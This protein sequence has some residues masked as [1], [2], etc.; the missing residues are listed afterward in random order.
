MDARSLSVCGQ[1]QKNV[2]FKF[3]LDGNEA[4]EI[5]CSEFLIQKLEYTHNNSVRAEIIENP[6]DYKYRSAINNADRK[7]LLEVI[8]ISNGIFTLINIISYRNPIF[9]REYLVSL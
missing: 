8:L 4:K 7:G 6:I 3:W 9:C 5:H 1:I 2:S